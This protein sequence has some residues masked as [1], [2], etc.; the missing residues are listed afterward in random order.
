[1]S[2]TKYAKAAD[3]GQPAAVAQ[4][5]RYGY[6]RV[7]KQDQHPEAQH[8]ALIAAGCD[9]KHL[10][11]EKISSRV[12]VRPQLEAALAYLRPGDTLVITKLD[13]LG[14]SV[15]DLI[16]LVDRIKELGVDLVILHQNIDTSTPS[17]KMFFHI[18]AAFAEFEREMI[19]VRTI[20]GLEAAKLRNRVGGRRR[21][22]ND[23]QQARLFEMYAAMEPVPGSNPGPGEEPKMRR[24]Y[25]NAQI[26]KELG[27]HRSVIPDYLAWRQQARE[28]AAAG[29]PRPAE[30][31][32]PWERS[33]EEARVARIYEMADTLMVPEQQ[34]APGQAPEIGWR[35]TIAEIA[36][37]VGVSR[38][39]V[40]KYLEAREPAEGA[41][42]AEQQEE[43]D[44][45]NL[46]AEA[47]R[48]LDRAE[49]EGRELWA[50]R[51]S[52]SQTATWECS[53][54]PLTTGSPPT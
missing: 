38:E 16:N 7:S 44:A 52:G 2:N 51:S 23:L 9:P 50:G 3:S 17:G 42:T 5:G 36:R 53:A 21:K 6:G 18:L 12:D 26:A 46:P 28:A 11:I 31:I 43:D 45:R 1:M 8:D 34:L 20:E 10:F 19:R 32:V 35:Y 13:R 39:T 15:R 49:K 22:L 4:G 48:H 41:R 29:Q 30:R 33:V 54:Q 25:S 14:R 27:I 40:Y 37:E 24:K 47:G